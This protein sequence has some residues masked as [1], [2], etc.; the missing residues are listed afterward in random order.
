M[1]FRFFLCLCIV[2]Q[3]CSNR[4]HVLRLNRKQLEP[5]AEIDTIESYANRGLYLINIIHN[6]TFGRFS[7]KYA[8]LKD[9]GNL[10]SIVYEVAE[11]KEEEGRISPN[12]VAFVKAGN[13][14]NWD[15]FSVGN[16]KLVDTLPGMAAILDSIKKTIGN[17]EVLR[18]INGYVSVYRS[19][20]PIRQL[21]Y[22]QLVTRRMDGRYD[23]LEPHL[24]QLL[25]D[26]LRLISVVAD[27][28]FKQKSGIY[29]IPAPGYGL[30]DKYDKRALLK[31]IDSV[32]ALPEPPSTLTIEA[33]P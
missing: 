16:G 21:D 11:P 10:A 9:R 12:Y 28:I 5:L 24:Y 14:V 2:L 15:W 32:S 25:Q 1:I 31:M 6:Y 23:S 4:A 22:G 18:E 17:D 20:K 7:T 8:I 27:D 3:A 29:F 19:G 33:T 13:K 26:S 30:V